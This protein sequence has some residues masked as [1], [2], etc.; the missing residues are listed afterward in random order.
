MQVYI[1]LYWQCIFLFVC[2]VLNETS[3]P[4]WTWM[5]RKVYQGPSEVQSSDTN[6]FRLTVL[7]H[8]SFFQS[9][10]THYVISN[11]KITDPNDYPNSRWEKARIGGG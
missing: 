5:K 2:F 1:I 4:S 8:T 7:K 10:F 11:L 6:I 9:H 3:F